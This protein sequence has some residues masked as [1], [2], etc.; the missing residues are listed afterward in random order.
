VAVEQKTCYQDDASPRVPVL[1]DAD[2]NNLL[3]LRRRSDHGIAGAIGGR[4]VHRHDAGNWYVQKH[5]GSHGGDY[6][7]CRLLGY[8]TPVRTSQ[9]THYVSVTESSQLLLT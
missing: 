4:R 3:R 6:E 2:D 9:E 5:A 7:E 1:L 8:K